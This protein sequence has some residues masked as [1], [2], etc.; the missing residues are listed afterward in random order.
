[1]TDDLVPSFTPALI[2]VLLNRENAKGEPLTE[3][4]VIEIRDSSVA[5]MVPRS[6]ERAL[7]ASR[8][9]DDIDPENVWAEWQRV[10]VELQEG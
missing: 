4:E 6:M 8:G 5:M 1:M 3:Q 2:A 10:R 7:A 9:Y